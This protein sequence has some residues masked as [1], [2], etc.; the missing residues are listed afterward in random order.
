MIM[1]N[2]IE[3]LINEYLPEA[4]AKYAKRYPLVSGNPDMLSMIDPED[5]AEALMDV[6]FDMKVENSSNAEMEEAL[7][8]YIY[9]NQEKIVNLISAFNTLY[10]K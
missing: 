10:F 3:F 6:E 4:I 2:Q 7:V 5:I 1:S 8:S 9:D